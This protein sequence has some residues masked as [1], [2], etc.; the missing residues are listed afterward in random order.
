M[1]KT[2]VVDEL[3]NVEIYNN[4]RFLET[5]AKRKHETSVTRSSHRGV[6]VLK[7]S[8]KD[9]L[10]NDIVNLLAKYQDYIRDLKNQGHVILG[11]CRKSRTAKNNATVI[12]SLKSMVTELQR[13][14]LVDLIKDLAKMD[15]ARLAIIDSA[16][17]TT[18]MDDLELFIRYVTYTITYGNQV[19]ILECEDEIFEKRSLFKFDGGENLFHR[20]KMLPT[21]TLM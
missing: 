17:L 15:K 10:L 13:R 1:L 6:Y 4:L 9:T 11:Y 14:S 21:P 12:E 8:Y 2:S 3:E 7:D 19:Y 20:S 18:N 16:G 5:G